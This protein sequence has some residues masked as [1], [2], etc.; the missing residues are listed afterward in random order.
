M[1]ETDILILLQTTHAASPK[2]FITTGDFHKRRRAI[3][4]GRQRDD[5]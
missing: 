2:A 3:N 4:T 1:R 5:A